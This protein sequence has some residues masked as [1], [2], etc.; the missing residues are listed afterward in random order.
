MRLQQ[1]QLILILFSI[2]IYLPDRAAATENRDSIV[3]LPIAIDAK[4][5][6]DLE[7]SFIEQ[8]RLGGNKI[9]GSASLSSE[10][11]SCRQA[12]CLSLIL[13]R[14][15]NAGRLLRVDIVTANTGA[16][17]GA[18]GAR[19]LRVEV[20]GFILSGK[21]SWSRSGFCTP[22]ASQKML[23]ATL[24]GVA[25]QILAGPPA[26][27][28]NPELV[29]P[30]AGET[31][32]PKH[33]RWPRSRIATVAVLGGASLLTLALA[34]GLSSLNGQP[35]TFAQCTPVNPTPLPADPKECLFR[36]LPELGGTLFASGAALGVTA[37][38]LALVWPGQA[39]PK[40]VATGPTANP[41]PD[42]ATTKAP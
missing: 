5:D 21:K 40:A 32:H 17:D 1:L 14:L 22:C 4:P 19:T 36:T 15:P 13:E 16:K 34:A 42:E 20:S 39:K 26:D 11:Q 35:T 3:V 12:A 6:P 2:G 10:E 37:I 33:S 23:L 18:A 7:Y 29:Q 41:L 38:A 31:P 24:A 9:V 30:P 27:T 8:L 28:Q 25:N